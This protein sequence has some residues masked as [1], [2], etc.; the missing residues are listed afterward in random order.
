MLLLLAV[1]SRSAVIP[2]RTGII[3]PHGGVN[4]TEGA[5]HFRLYGGYFP[6]AVNVSLP[7]VNHLNATFPA[8]CQRIVVSTR[9]GETFDLNHIANSTA[10][11]NT[12]CVWYAARPSRAVFVVRTRGDAHV[13]VDLLDGRPVG[14]VVTE[15]RVELDFEESLLF[16]WFTAPNSV[17][18]FANVRFAQRA[19]ALPFATQIFEDFAPTARPQLFAVLARAR[20]AARAIPSSTPEAEDEDEE[21]GPCP[22]A[23]IAFLCLLTGACCC[24]CFCCC[25]RCRSAQTRERAVPLTDIE[26]DAVPPVF[27]GPP[28]APQPYAWP[29]P[30]YGYPV[31]YQ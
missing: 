11:A 27:P 10:S 29:A 8:G 22:L 19:N 31:R 2:P 5:S 6:N 18:S 15:G 9:T 14:D 17:D 1:L 3:Y 4:F 13:V 20:G 23:G 7:I 30:Y 25:R 16:R 26:T 21:D 28:P 24:C 12:T